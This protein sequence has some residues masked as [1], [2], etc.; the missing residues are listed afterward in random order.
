MDILTK[1]Q[2]QFEVE[3]VVKRLAHAVDHEK[4]DIWD[5]SFTPDAFIDFKDLSGTSGTPDFYKARMRG[6][7]EG[8]IAYQHLLSNQIST[9]FDGSAT[10]HSEFAV[11]IA[12]KA[13][14]AGHIDLV[15]LHG[16]YVDELKYTDQGWLIRHR[17]GVLKWKES[18][19]VKN[20]LDR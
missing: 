6:S 1:I 13:Q 16:F 15:S 5:E 19:T 3:N 18:R 9:F 7:K 14:E 8:R 20:E 11:E 17:K 2:R 12:S 10:V 4:W